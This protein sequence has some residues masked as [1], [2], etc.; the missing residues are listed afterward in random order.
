VTV[1]L[2]LLG[3]V[4]AVGQRMES[5]VLLLVSSLITLNQVHMYDVEQQ[6]LRVAF[7]LPSGALSETPALSADGSQIA[8]ILVNGTRYDLYGSNLLGHSRHILTLEHA[9]S[10]LHWSP[11]GRWLAAYVA[12]DSTDVYLIDLNSEQLT[13]IGVLRFDDYAESWSPNGRWL[14]ITVVKDSSETYLVNMDVEPFTAIRPLTYLARFLCW[15]PDGS[16]MAVSAESDAGERLY[17]LT[18]ATG[19]LQLLAEPA[20]GGQEISAAWSPSGSS[21]VYSA[22]SD[23]WIADLMGGMSRLTNDGLGNVNPSW[24]PDGRHI[25]FHSYRDTGQPLLHIMNA[26]GSQLRDLNTQPVGRYEANPTWSPDSAYVALEGDTAGEVDVYLN[27]A[28]GT[29]SLHITPDPPDCQ[30]H[31]NYYILGWLP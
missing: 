1:F 28:E 2:M 30:C 19:R 20:P 12:G 14:A 25:I 23:L 21:I 4:I 3:S 11:D 24:S 13:N 22:G 18:L 5:H 29:R 7:T 31:P 8:Y 15:S 17:V 16:Q 9:L 26:D 6:S 10:G 27:N